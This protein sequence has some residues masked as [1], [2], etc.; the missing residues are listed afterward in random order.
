MAF[1]SLTCVPFHHAGRTQSGIDVQKLKSRHYAW[2]RVVDFSCLTGSVLYLC[3]HPFGPRSLGLHPYVWE[4][5]ELYI[6]HSDEFSE[7]KN[8][9]RDVML[10]YYFFLT[11]PVSFWT[12][13]RAWWREQLVKLILMLQSSFLFCIG[14]CCWFHFRQLQ[15]KKKE[16][17]K[18]KCTFPIRH[19]LLQGICLHLDHFFQQQQCAQS[20]TCLYHCKIS[21]LQFEKFKKQTVNFFKRRYT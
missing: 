16:K 15:V 18:I 8:I 21:K 3:S 13:N 10:I 11:M 20:S 12:I 17:D 6:R 14:G 19:R 2:F 7:T 5:A 9:H 4:R 1:L